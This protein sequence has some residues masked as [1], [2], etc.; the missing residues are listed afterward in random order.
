MVWHFGHWPGVQW[1]VVEKTIYKTSG[2][3]VIA[4]LSREGFAIVDRM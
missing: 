1:D 2:G 4:S 3:V